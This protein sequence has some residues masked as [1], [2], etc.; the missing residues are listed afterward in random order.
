MP[1]KYERKEERLWVY[2]MAAGEHAFGEERFRLRAHPAES[3]AHQAKAQTCPGTLPTN[4]PTWDCALRLR[5]LGSRG[6]GAQASVSTEPAA[7]SAQPLTR[8]HRI[9]RATETCDIPAFILS[10]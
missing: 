7:S 2:T 3:R 6:P 1:S 4:D 5:T 10:F 8:F 9:R